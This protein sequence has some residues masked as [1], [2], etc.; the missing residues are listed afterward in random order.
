[1]NAE[2]TFRQ[3]CPRHRAHQLEH[4]NVRLGRRR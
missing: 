2:R 4:A 1:M 3:P